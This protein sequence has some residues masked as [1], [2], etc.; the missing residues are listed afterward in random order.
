MRSHWGSKIGF[1]LA[2][3]GSAIGLGNIWRFPY[4]VA[5]N[6]GGAFLL[7]YL[8]CVVFLGYFL[9]ASKLTFGRVAQTNIVDAFQKVSPKKVSGLWGKCV[10]YANLFNV[11][12]LV[13]VYAIVIGWTLSYVATGVRNLFEIK[14]LEINASLFETL[15]SSYFEQLFWIVLSLFVTGQ[16]LIKGVRKGI[17]KMS[18]YLMPILFLL[19]ILMVCRMAFIPNAQEGFKYLFYPNWE[20]LGFGLGGFEW[21]TFAHITLLA[22]GQAIYSLSL[23]V[24]VCFIYGSYLGNGIDIK[25]SA[26]YVAGFD[27]LVAI[28]ASMIVVPAVFTFNLELNQGTTLS[29]VTLPFVFKQMFGGKIIML[30]F[31]VL[32]FFGAL[33]S[34]VS[35]YEPL[36]NIITEKMKL[37]RKKATYSVLAVNLGLSFIVLASFTGVLSFKIFGRNLFDMFD[38]LTGTYTFGMF[39]LV[40]CVFMGW[41]I[42]PQISDDLNLKSNFLK[43]YFC[44][45]LRWLAPAI[46][47]L[48]FL[49]A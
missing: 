34:I 23:G 39:E 44:F 13:S 3:A 8:I 41:K 24:G 37:N 6:G 7:I 49:T 17:E 11:F 25:R 9:L 22:L 28:L 32:L 14:P 38:Y 10:G 30:A 48:L 35:M 36:I 46:F 19:L 40:I 15:A 5:Q 27:T 29:F 4:L 20:R 2:M 31:F 42:F 26:L 12:L 45:I 16:I 1:I 33:T 43:A 21:R 18:L 47:L